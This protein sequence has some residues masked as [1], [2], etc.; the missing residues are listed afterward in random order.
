V[1]FKKH[2]ENLPFNYTYNDAPGIHE[3]GFWDKNIQDILKWIDR[4]QK[5]TEIC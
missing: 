2:I 3:W 1:K 4:S 5:T